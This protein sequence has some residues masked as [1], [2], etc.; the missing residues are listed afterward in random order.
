MRKTV[1]IFGLV[2]AALY[3]AMM[4]ATFPLIDAIG[5]DK[6]DLIGY[7]TIVLAALLV[8][9]GIRSYRETAGEGRVTFARAFLVGVLIT[10]VASLCDV[11]AFQAAY[12]KLMP[13]LGEKYAACMVERVRVAGGSPQKIEEAAKQ[14]ET[15]KRLWDDPLTNAALAF[16]EPFPIG[17]LAAAV[18]AAILRKR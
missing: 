9:F 10:L 5:I 12:F 14:A 3:A 1:L 11:A 4:L 6:T 15:L 2:S 18:S 13:Q 17:L 8:F 7:T 16:A